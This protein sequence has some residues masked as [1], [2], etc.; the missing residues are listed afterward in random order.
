MHALSHTP[1]TAGQPNKLVK[2]ADQSLKAGDCL[3][4]PGRT[5]IKLLEA[6]LT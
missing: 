3:G 6:Q 5:T 4:G 2:E 1:G